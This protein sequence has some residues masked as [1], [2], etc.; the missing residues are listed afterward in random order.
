MVSSDRFLNAFSYEGI[1][2]KRTAP[3]RLTG[4]VSNIEI[5]HLLTDVGLPQ[6]LG[7]DLFFHNIEKDCITLEEQR[8]ESGGETSTEMDDLLYMGAGVQA[9]IILLD[10]LTG[11][12][13]TWK[14]DH[15]V[16]INAHLQFFLD[17]ICKIQEKINELEESEG[18]SDGEY[19][20]L[21]TS[22]L[23]DLQIIDPQAPTQAGGYW[24][25]MLQSIL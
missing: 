14:D 13:L 24:D 19:E 20:A 9:G 25:G 10:S 11:E 7:D 3:S 8:R 21:I 2:V 4:K 17:F 6:Q 16:S 15:L 22:F 23:Q 18:A 5:V 12:V 1:E